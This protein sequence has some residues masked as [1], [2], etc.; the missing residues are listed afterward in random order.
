MRAR[1]L[2]TDEFDGGL[3]LTIA[4]SEPLERLVSLVVQESECCAFYRFTMHVDGPARV[5]EIDA[6]PGNAAAARALVGL[7]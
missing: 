2:S 7:D 6:G 1:A 4:Q 3:R 5:L